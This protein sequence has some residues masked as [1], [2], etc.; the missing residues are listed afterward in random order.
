MIYVRDVIYLYSIWIFLRTKMEF[1]GRVTVYSISGCPFCARA[2]SLLTEV[3]VPYVD[4]NLDAYPERRAE[5]QERT[6]RRT[7]PQIFF[8]DKHIGGCDELRKLV[9]AVIN[10][11]S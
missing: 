6:G 9:S 2:K 1:K 5:V 11:S 7:V 4:I 10:T 3:G 8:N